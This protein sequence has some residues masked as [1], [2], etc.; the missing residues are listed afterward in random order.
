MYF[1]RIKEVIMIND[2]DRNDLEH[3][4]FSD[5]GEDAN[6]KP[7]AKHLGNSLSKFDAS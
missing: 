5:P 1:Q 3:L 7:T 2:L 6:L 4:L